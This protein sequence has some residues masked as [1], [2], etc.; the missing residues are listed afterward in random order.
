MH[1]PNRIFAVGLLGLLA[2][3]AQAQEA[4]DT[5]SA[6][7][8]WEPAFRAGD[9]DAVAECYVPDAVMWFPGGPMAQGQDAIRAGYAGYFAAFTIKDVRLAEMGRVRSGDHLTTWGRFE[10]VMVARDGGAE[11]VERGRYTDVAVN[12]DGAWL[13]SVDHASDDPAPA[14]TE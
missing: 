8:C 4:L 10:I 9:A 2:S 13:Y 3:S 12:V 7:D 1:L 14:D 11:V 6:Q 5:S